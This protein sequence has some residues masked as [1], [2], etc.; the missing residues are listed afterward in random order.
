MLCETLFVGFSEG[1]SNPFEAFCKVLLTQ[2]TAIQTIH[3]TVWATTQCL[4]ESSHWSTISCVDGWGMKNELS[5]ELV[6]VDAMFIV[7][8][9]VLLLMTMISLS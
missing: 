2:N 5:K 3:P 4:W 8:T 1:E 6:F 9:S 7:L